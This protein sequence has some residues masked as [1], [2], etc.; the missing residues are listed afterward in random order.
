MEVV[1]D[2]QV[3][4][5]DYEEALVYLKFPYFDE[6]SFLMNS[7]NTTIELIDIDSA[8]PKCKIG[9]LMFSGH[10]EVNIGTLLFF[11]TPVEEENSSKSTTLVGK[12][13]TCA[14]FQLTSIGDAECLDNINNTSGSPTNE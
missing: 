3:T 9:E 7:P 4:A 11:D 2:E 12:T 10:Y 8:T 1:V 14:S 5:D 13:I 6:Q